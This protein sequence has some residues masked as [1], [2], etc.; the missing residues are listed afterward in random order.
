[1]APP[2]RHSPAAQHHPE[3]SPDLRVFTAGILHA[4][5]ASER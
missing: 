3:R 4:A 5:A 1:M 2:H